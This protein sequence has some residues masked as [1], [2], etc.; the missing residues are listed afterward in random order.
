MTLCRIL[1]RAKKD[2]VVSKRVAASWVKKTYGHPWI[3]LIEKA[4]RWQHGQ[5]MDTVQELLRFIEFV[6]QEVK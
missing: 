1:H 2:S 5:E 6:S 3:D 4:E